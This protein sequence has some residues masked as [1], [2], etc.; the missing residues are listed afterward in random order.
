MSVI[1]VPWDDDVHSPNP[2]W[3]WLNDNAPDLMY[4]Y[5]INHVRFITEKQTDWWR[6]P[7]I[8]STNGVVYGFEQDITPSEGFEISVEIE[9]APKVQIFLFY[10]DQATLFLRLNETTWVKAGLEFDNDKVWAGAVVTSPYS[11]WSIQPKPNTNITRFTISLKNQ[12]LIIY[13]NDEMIREVNVFGDENSKSIEK[14][15]VGVMG[16]S[17]KGDGA[18]VDFKNFTLRKGVRS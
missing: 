13:L 16:C 11:D 9:L 17:P 1:S 10:S 14:A 18:Q 4:Y 3:N 8:N 2:K 6:T 15:F 12:K 7:D 5:S